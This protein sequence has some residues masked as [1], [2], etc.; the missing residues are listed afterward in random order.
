MKAS[1]RTSKP[2]VDDDPVFRAVVDSIP[3]E[4][5]P[6]VDAWMAKKLAYEMIRVA[7]ADILHEKRK[8]RA[9]G[10]V[11]TNKATFSAIRWVRS[12]NTGALSF[13]TCC[14]ILELDPA[15]VRDQILST[16]SLL[17]ELSL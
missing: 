1:K 5:V 12:P 4:A 17:P 14:E 15:K 8:L 11:L 10:R 9:Q 6:P 13:N 2:S 7:H 16:D 3:D